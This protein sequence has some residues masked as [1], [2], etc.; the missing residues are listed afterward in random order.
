[1][2]RNLLE[3]P[4]RVNAPVGL[5]GGNDHVACPMVVGVE[6][7]ELDKAHDHAMLARENGESFDFVVINAAHENGIYFCG[8]QQG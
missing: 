7:H 2:V 8:S 1:M 3:R 5:R 4:A 6:G